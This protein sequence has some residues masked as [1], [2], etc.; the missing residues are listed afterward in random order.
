MRAEAR[1]AA[2]RKPRLRV[3]DVAGE[4]GLCQLPRPQVPRSPG[5]PAGTARQGCGRSAEDSGPRS[6]C[7][8]QPGEALGR[9]L[10]PAAPRRFTCHPRGGARRC[11]PQQEDEEPGQ[12]HC[13]ARGCMAAAKAECPLPP[14]AWAGRPLPPS[15]PLR[16]QPRTPPKARLS[17]HAHDQNELPLLPVASP[18]PRR[19][20]WLPA[21]R[22][23]LARL[24]PLVTHA[25]AGGGRAGTVV[26]PSLALQRLRPGRAKFPSHARLPAVLASLW[27]AE[28]L[29]G[30]VV[31][32]S[33]PRGTVHT[34]P[35]R[36]QSCQSAKTRLN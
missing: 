15:R 4:R 9:A 34:P 1:G 11:R 21:A 27:P 16:L 26:S 22:L 31:Q 30:S 10:L 29:P 12:A 13:A 6:C 25:P 35:P 36:T 28:P 3:C 24:I 14:S 23:G 18:P 5:G 20:L 32:L 33:T 8:W 17:A 19:P 2:C 7:R